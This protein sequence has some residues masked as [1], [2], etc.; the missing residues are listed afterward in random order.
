MCHWVRLQRSVLLT[1]CWRGEGLIG[2]VGGTDPL[3]GS[4]GMPPPPK[5]F[6]IRFINQVQFKSKTKR[7][8]I[9]RALFSFKQFC[10]R[11]II[12]FKNLFLPL[13]RLLLWC[14]QPKFTSAHG[15]PTVGGTPVAVCSTKMQYLTGH[16][17]NDSCQGTIL[18]ML[19]KFSWQTQWQTRN[20]WE[21]LYMCLQLQMPKCLFFGVFA[22]IILVLA[23]KIG[24]IYILIAS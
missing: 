23:V 8:D 7:L 16:D 17:W 20:S 6:F 2:H 11:H 12:R 9:W 10:L 3:K 18:L 21:L 4:V 5:D 19:A 13:Y 15:W 24:K 14:M 1:S 22:G